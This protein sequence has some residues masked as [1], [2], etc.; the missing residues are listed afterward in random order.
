MKPSQAIIQAL[1]ALRDEEK[2]IFLQRFFKTGPGQYAEGDVFW[3]IV[4]PEQRKI[5]K[6]FWKD[7]STEDIAALLNHPAH[8]VR[9]TGALVLIQ[10]TQK[11]SSEDEIK[12]WA[13][14]YLDNKAGINNWDLVDNSA[15]HVLGRWLH[16]KTDRSVLQTLSD[17][18]NLWDNR[19][20]ILTTF[21]FLKKGDFEDTFY[22]AE[23]MMHHPH[24]LMHKAIGWMIREVG[25]RDFDAAY[26]FLVKYYS[27]MPRT[28]LRYAIEKFEEPMRKDFLEGRI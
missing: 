3:G 23:K 4:L 15:H 19:I 22:L 5:V 16:E 12:Q 20:S 26:G 8:E 6:Q 14:V 13:Q 11:S 18:P 21:Y 2:A 28:M 25:K 7:C 24:D 10:K 1:S 17:S 27:R 9:M